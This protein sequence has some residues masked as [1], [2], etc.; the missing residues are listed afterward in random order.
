MGT[1][2]GSDPMA[3]KSMI[4]VNMIARDSDDTILPCLK[5][6]MPFVGRIHVGIDSRS[7][8]STLAL[9]SQ[10]AEE[11]PDKIDVEVFPVTD[12]LTDLVK[13]RQG[14]VDKSFGRWIWVVDSDEY[15]PAPVALNTLSMLDMNY[16]VY[17]FRCWAVWDRGRAHRASSMAVIPRIFL[18]DESRAWRGTFGKEVL[19]RADEELTL[20]PY[21]YIHLTHLKKDNWRWEMNQRRI[22]DDKHLMALPP[23]IDAEI[24]QIFG[25][26]HVPKPRSYTPLG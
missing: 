14:L 20:I 19:H 24:S 12:P 8:D 2:N 26:T 16:P 4:A 21:R 9:V 10:L 22:A 23:E 15:Y 6:I 7:K 1:E 13:M 25:G 11:N 3:E 18:N 17:A 5:A